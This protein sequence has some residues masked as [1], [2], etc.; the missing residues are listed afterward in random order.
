MGFWRATR[1]K[2]V[3]SL[4]TSVSKFLE[5]E[6]LSFWCT[7]VDPS[8]SSLPPPYPTHPP[9]SYVL[10]VDLCTETLTL[11]ILDLD[12]H[13][14]ICGTDYSNLTNCN[15]SSLDTEILC[16]DVFFR[17]SSSRKEVLE[18]FSFRDVSCGNGGWHGIARKNP[19]WR[20]ANCHSE[21]A[22]QSD[23]KVNYNHAPE[24]WL[25]SN[26]LHYFSYFLRGRKC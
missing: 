14:H 6:I 12:Q 21:W 13:W 9:T 11:D 8:I 18:M 15:S 3:S 20:S 16:R 10:Q 24:T 7:K 26:V 1:R 23:K 22:Q 4:R 17:S 25:E 5:L 2:N 19:F